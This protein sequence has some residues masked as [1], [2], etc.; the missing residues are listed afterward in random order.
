MKKVIRNVEN[1]SCLGGIALICLFALGTDRAT[2]VTINLNGLLTNG[3]FESPSGQSGLTPVCPTS[4]SCSGTPAPG[5]GTYTPTTQ[6]YTPG[7]DGLS[8]G[9]LVPGGTQAAFAPTTIEGSSDMWQFVSGLTYVAGNTYTLSFW[10]G[11]PMTEPGTNSAGMGCNINPL[12]SCLV[13]GIPPTSQ[14][15][16]VVPNGGTGFATSGIAVDP[17]TI[18]S[19]GLGMWALET[20]SFTASAGGSYIGQTVGIDFHEA[21]TQNNQ[22]INFDIVSVPE[23]TTLLL[24]GSGLVGLALLRKRYQRPKR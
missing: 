9:K 8:G 2:A 22:S 18:T 7:A 1:Y 21:T 6:Q 19:P 23:P 11:L 20:V 5:F 17:I 15:N 16:F 12:V 24:A 3:S 4:W 10:V 13:T 14:F